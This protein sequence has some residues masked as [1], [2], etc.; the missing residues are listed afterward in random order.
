MT[1]YF[2]FGEALRHDQ[3]L[4]NADR[5]TILVTLILLAAI[6]YGISNGKAWVVKQQQAVA[7]AQAEEK[8][9]L[10]ENRDNLVAM[11]EGKYVA[12]TAYRNPANPLW[13]GNRHA[14]TYAVLPPT[15]LAFTAIGQS[16]LNPPYIT[17]SADSKE[18]FI[19][20]EEIES[21]G[22]LLIGHFDLSFFIVFLF[23]L[24]IIALSYN[25]LS[26]EREQGTLAILMSNPIRLGTLLLAKLAF[27]ARLVILPIVVMTAVFVALYGAQLFSIDSAVRLAWWIALTTAYGAFW[28]AVAAAVGVLGKS[29][30]HNALVLAGV[31][32]LFSLIVPTLLSIAVNV[33]YPVPS[34]VEMV[35]SLRAIQTR[36][37][38]EY[39]A[40]VA[41]YQDEH[42]A[43]ATDNG[44]LNQKDLDSAHR[45]VLVQQAAAKSI[46]ERMARHDDQLARQQRVV[47]WLRFLSP[48][49][50]MQEALNDVAGTG[51]SRYQHYTRQVDQFHGDWQAFFVTRVMTNTALTVEDYDRFPRFQYL[52]QPLSELNPRLFYALLGLLVPIAVLGY[53]SARRVSHYPIRN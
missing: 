47:D 40:T 34:R 15:A 48:A 39:D 5:L 46:E 51:N 12:A 23:P 42:T 9:R 28:F 21:P 30:E 13:V 27:R 37:G 24:L 52:Q 53:F 31:W 18:T 8:K 6:G 49:I 45:R 38:N 2:L 16:D 43:M 20:N 17:V 41:R 35:N 29:S 19:F 14:A 3:R 4:F 26:G 50:V 25:V 11:Q 33:A 7:A 22:N 36:A 32:V 10:K 1:S 44:V